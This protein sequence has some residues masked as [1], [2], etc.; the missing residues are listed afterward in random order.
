MHFAQTILQA[1]SFF[2]RGEISAALKL[3]TDAQRHL[4]FKEML[5]ITNPQVSELQ[6]HRFA[7][8]RLLDA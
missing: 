4:L 3:Y 1:N 6:Q 8:F 5:P 2:K 7:C